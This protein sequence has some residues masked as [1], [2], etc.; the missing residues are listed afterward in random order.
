LIADQLF[1]ILASKENK[2]SN[3]MLLKMLM[4]LLLLKIEELQIMCK[5]LVL[6]HLLCLLLEVVYQI[7]MQDLEYLTTKEKRV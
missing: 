1:H 2:N 4:D 6:N 7:Q 3:L 5:G